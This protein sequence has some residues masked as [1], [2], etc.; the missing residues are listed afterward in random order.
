MLNAGNIIRLQ[1]ITAQFLIVFD[2]TCTVLSN[3]A[4]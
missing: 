3:L 1:H 2:P 4:S